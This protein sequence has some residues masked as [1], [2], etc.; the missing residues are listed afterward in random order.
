MDLL[1]RKVN[2]GYIYVNTKNFKMGLDYH[3]RMITDEKEVGE[4]LQRERI[5][6]SA[7]FEITEKCNFDCYYCY[8]KSLKNQNDLDTDQIKQILDKLKKTGIIF[9]NITG[10]EVLARKDI[11]EILKYINEQKFIL[12]VFTN[13]SLL[14]KEIIDELKSGYVKIINISLIAPTEEQFDKL[15]GKIG[16]FKKFISGLDLLKNNNLKFNVVT[17]LTSENIDLYDAFENF[18]RNYNTKIRFT[19]DVGPTFEGYD[20]IENYAVKKSQIENLK[21]FYGKNI[22]NM[23]KN[24]R[25]YGC[26][27]GQSNFAIT[28]QGKVL[29]CM[30]FR[31]EVGNILDSNF[32]DIWESD[33]MKGIIKNELKRHEKCNKCEKRDYCLYCPGEVRM[34]EDISS[35]CK[36]AEILSQVDTRSQS[37]KSIDM[38][39][40]A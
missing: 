38:V 4:I 39:E 22:E 26:S 29:P 7:T 37:K 10:G 12:G 19:Y 15:S 20:M 11:L 9:L 16:N 24:I 21:K 25:E 23:K 36:S 8:A 13:G 30:K 5:P 28:N 33:E 3:G 17:T 40:G 18:M 27:A 31:K 32:D 14:T 2:F 34:Y 6:I 35:K 1:K